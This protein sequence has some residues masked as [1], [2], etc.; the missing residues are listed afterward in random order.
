MEEART[1]E[2]RATHVTHGTAER[3]LARQTHGPWARRGNT[4]ANVGGAKQEG[5]GRRGVGHP[6]C[7]GNEGISGPR[8]AQV[9][10]RGN[11]E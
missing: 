9:L 7:K 5:H 2:G 10:G 3:T 6:T 11:P 4:I 1:N 8:G